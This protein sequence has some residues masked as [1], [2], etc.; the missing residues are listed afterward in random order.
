M[1]LFGHQHY[2]YQRLVTATRESVVE[3]P[4]GKRVAAIRIFCCPTTLQYDAKGNGFYLFD[5]SS[6][7][8][9]EWTSIGALRTEGERESPM[10]QL[11]RA[12]FDLDAEPTSEE[13]QGSHRV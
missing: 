9:V 13:I 4:F 2:P 5:F 8:Q 1:I 3:T 7:S 6:K 12:T 11:D 10:K